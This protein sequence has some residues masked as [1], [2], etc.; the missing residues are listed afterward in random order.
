MKLKELVLTNNQIGDKGI[1]AFAKH[2][3]K[4]EVLNIR[5]NHITDTGMMALIEGI[6]LN[7]FLKEL[8]MNFNHIT[9][10]GAL[11]LAK[12]LGSLTSFK[13]LDLRC[14]KIGD[15]GA[16]AVAKTEENF[17]LLIW[18]PKLT[19]DGISTIKGLRP[20]I[21]CDDDLSVLSSDRFAT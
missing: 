3:A 13:K 20:D 12:C 8:N 7:T 18:N 17:Q 11:H 19:P 6:Q 4:L 16:I 21:I 2:C 10:I 15:E 14:N 1:T 5:A 9:D